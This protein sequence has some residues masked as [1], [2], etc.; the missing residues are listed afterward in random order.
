MWR[1]ERAAVTQAV[2]VDDC[3]EGWAPS[4]EGQRRDTLDVYAQS[5]SR[6]PCAM[7]AVGAVQ[8]QRGET[9]SA[10][11]AISMGA[12]SFDTHAIVFRTRRRVYS[13]RRCTL[14]R[15]QLLV[16]PHREAHIPRRV[17]QQDKHDDGRQNARM[18]TCSSPYNAN[19]FL[20][21]SLLP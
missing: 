17:E 3:V 1:T 10:M 7:T 8:A 4:S 5:T 12:F 20:Y 15:G 2:G 16:G 6:R 18:S 19:S 14:S 11:G 13:R 21:V 9:R